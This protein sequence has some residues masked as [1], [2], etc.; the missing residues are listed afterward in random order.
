[1]LQVVSD[2]PLIQ[3]L[4]TQPFRRFTIVHSY[5]QDELFDSIIPISIHYK[6]KNNINFYFDPPN[7]DCLNLSLNTEQKTL[8]INSILFNRSYQ[9][10]F[11]KKIH[12]NKILTFCKKLADDLDCYKL[13]LMD[14]T[15]IPDLDYFVD[16]KFLSLMS[17]GKTIYMKQG[18]FYL[19]T[20]FIEQVDMFL[21]K[22][23]LKREIILNNLNVI[24][25]AFSIL[26]LKCSSSLKIH[27][28]FK[29]LPLLEESGLTYNSSI[30]DLSTWLLRELKDPKNRSNIDYYHDLYEKLYR[31]FNGKEKGYYPDLFFFSINL[32]LSLPRGVSPIE[33]FLHQ[34]FRLNI[35][36]LPKDLDYF[37]LLKVLIG[38]DENHETCMYKLIEGNWT[39]FTYRQQQ[40]TRPQQTTRAQQQQFSRPQQ[41]T[42]PQQQQVTRPQQQQATRPQQQAARQQQQDIRPKR[43]KF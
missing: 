17:S 35:S 15:Y 29:R 38:N 43:R 11:G 39:Q 34:R 16:L 40:A 36:S 24:N 37:S 19:P 8:K 27:Q 42:R 2:K 28:V 12:L 1:M 5:I 23:P 14:A 6:S 13:Y 22:Y 26:I 30:K 21:K 3:T 4:L 7:E 9:E 33:L 25:R 10:C 18:F 31:V 41:T 20:K 32:V